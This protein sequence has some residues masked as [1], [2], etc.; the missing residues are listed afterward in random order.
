VVCENYFAW[1][2][3]VS[4][5]EKSGINLCISYKQK[6]AD[7]L[8]I[9]WGTI[10]I[11][12]LLA[13]GRTWTGKRTNTFWLFCEVHELIAENEDVVLTIFP[14][15][16]KFSFLTYMFYE[17]IHIRVAINWKVT[18]KCKYLT[19]KQPSIMNILRTSDIVIFC[20]LSWSFWNLVTGCRL[21]WCVSVTEYK[22]HNEACSQMQLVRTRQILRTACRHF[23]LCFDGV[24]LGWIL[25]IPAVRRVAEIS[26]GGYY[27]FHQIERVEFECI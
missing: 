10:L 6:L 1:E 24:L 12:Y 18:C 11:I 23:S 25:F 2:K 3:T 9:Y 19:Y 27:K 21:W 7:R 26:Y 17:I 4:Q 14:K 15:H 5:N 20:F 16:P 22:K 13:F 8:L